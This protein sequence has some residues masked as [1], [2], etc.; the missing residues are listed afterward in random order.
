ME[1]GGGNLGV[2][3]PMRGVIER[4]VRMEGVIEGR[5]SNLGAGVTIWG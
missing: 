3:G 5:E 2:E 4:P 1:G